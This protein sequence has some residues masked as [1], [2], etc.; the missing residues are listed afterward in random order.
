MTLDALHCDPE[1]TA[2]IEQGQGRYIVQVKENQAGLLEDMEQIPRFT[3]LASRYESL[4]KGHGRVERRVGEFY[5][6]EEEYFDKRWKDSGPRTLGVIK[7][8]TTV[9]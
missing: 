1:T 8:Q 3:R 2:M 6:I 9:L 4:E 7:R 5:S